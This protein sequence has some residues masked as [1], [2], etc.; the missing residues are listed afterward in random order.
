[1]TRM[2]I[3]TGAPEPT[4]LDWSEKSLLPDS[5]HVEPLTSP[6]SPSSK[7]LGPPWRQITT[8]KLQMRPVLPKL[9]IDARPPTE[10]VDRSGAE[11][12]SADEFVGPHTPGS[13]ASGDESQ[14]S[15][16]SAET[17]SETL[18][19]YYDH[20]FAIHEA[21]PSSQL[22]AFSDYTP[23]TPTYESTEEMLPQ[24]PSTGG[25]IIRTPSQRR[26]SQAP[27]PKHL[28]D[29]EDIPNARYLSSI[30]PQTMTVN[31]IVGILSIAPPRTVMT[32]I[33]YGKPRE[34]ELVEMVVGDDTK[35]GFGLSMWLP[36]EMR[37]NW[38]DGAN[39]NPEGSRSVLRRNLRHMRPRDVVLLQ[40]VALSSFRGKVHGQSLKGDVTKI[41]LLFRKKVDDDDLGGIYSVSNLR[42]ATGKDPQILKV[43]KVRDWLMEFVGDRDGPG[44]G[45]K[46]RRRG[47]G[48]R[49]D[50]GFLPDDTQ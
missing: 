1:M 34:T 16:G 39:A 50:H 23:G 22:S 47:G 20:S 43:K 9:N 17:I 11:F 3:L 44:A 38:K 12:F 37:V 29:L 4:K 32:G 5:T 49:R 28:S 31:L 33:K 6:T 24:T 14:R 35:T 13:D 7:V 10:D 42:T 41:D 46:G 8:Q 25:G 27:R 18:S 15:G 36:R 21:I 40:N 30:E 2:I 19:E 45:G 26:L 48:G